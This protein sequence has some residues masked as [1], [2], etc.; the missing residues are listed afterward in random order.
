[1]IDQ[2]RRRFFGSLFSAGAAVTATLAGDQVRAGDAPAARGGIDGVC[3]FVPSLGE[4]SAFVEAMRRN[5][6]GRWTAHPLQGGLT[7]SYFEARSVYEEARGRANTFVGAVDAATFA[8][9][10]EAIVD[11]GGSFHYVT[12]EDGGRVVFSA[13]V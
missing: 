11:G 6:P 3:L 2:G 5:A 13:Q 12:Y 7:E 1:M 10:Q 8:V 9:V 4:A